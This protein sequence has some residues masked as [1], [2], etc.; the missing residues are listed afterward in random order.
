MYLC[1]RSGSTAISA[2]EATLAGAA[3]AAG[4]MGL[5]T[6]GD[7]VVDASESE[8]Y[9]LVVRTILVDSMAMPKVLLFIVSGMV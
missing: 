8:S 7:G 9:V 4:L 5:D 2:V 1:L 3:K 6:N